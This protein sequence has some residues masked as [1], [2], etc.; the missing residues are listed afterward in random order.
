MVLIMMSGLVHA[1]ANL[2]ITNAH[3]L[4]DGQFTLIAQNRNDEPLD[5]TTT[6][7]MLFHP[8]LGL[9]PTQGSWDKKSIVQGTTRSQ[10]ATYLSTTGNAN[11]SGNYDGA[12]YYEGCKNELCRDTFRLSQCPEF[13]YSCD[14]V[15]LSMERCF[16]HGNEVWL[17]FS[18]LNKGQYEP[19]DPNTAFSVSLESNARTV[20]KTAVIK[21][22]QLSRQGEDIYTLKIPM[23]KNEKVFEVSLSMRQCSNVPPLTCVLGMKP[24]LERKLNASFAN[25]NNTNARLNNNATIIPTII[26]T[27]GTGAADK[28][29]SPENAS[30]K[31]NG[32]E[33]NRENQTDQPVSP[34]FP[35]S[36]AAAEPAQ[37][38]K[39][40][41]TS[42]TPSKRILPPKKETMTP[43][44]KIML[45]VVFITWLIALMIT[46]VV[47]LRDRKH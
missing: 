35:P 36:P 47:L 11:H 20:F 15:S 12:A 27:A 45:T 25:A 16:V 22:M 19:I 38:E 6:Q 42:P 23:E 26:T 31:E 39:T 1:Y 32:E 41:K 46:I 29:I 7:V 8:K 4:E 33:E 9:F 28:S 43:L 44:T 13:T 34:L 5:L 18:G 40:G 24:F 37:K 3:C 21:G 2:E 17:R 14:L 30:K 10:T